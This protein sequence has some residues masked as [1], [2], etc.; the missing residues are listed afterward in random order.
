VKSRW[1]EDN[2]VAAIGDGVFAIAMT[3]LV[4]D[5]K[6]PEL[7]SPVSS[8]AFRDA[9]VGQ[10]PRFVSWIISFAILCR[11]W[12]VQYALLELHQPKSR[13]FTAFNFAFLAAISLVPYPTSLISEHPEQPLA[14]VVFSLT[15]VAAW[16]AIVGMERCKDS[17]DSDTQDRQDLRSSVRLV[18]GLMPAIA[19][20]SIL[21]ALWEPRVG[22]FVWVLLP[23]T[24]RWV[25]HR[26]AR[27]G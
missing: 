13:T 16:G 4:L 19:V 26:K 27:A 2:R 11:L 18:M 7:P 1:F 20:A 15:M 10:G 5:L 21:L 22:A 6:L 25:K 3:L 23:V 9:V 8:Q 24:G 14:V 17:G 12:I